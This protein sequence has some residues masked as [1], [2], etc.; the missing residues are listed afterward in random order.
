MVITTQWYIP[1][2]GKY[3]PIIGNGTY[4]PIQLAIVF[5]IDG[6][7]HS[8]LCFSRKHEFSFF[9]TANSFHHE[10]MFWLEGAEVKCSYFKQNNYHPSSPWCCLID[11]VNSMYVKLHTVLHHNWKMSCRC[12]LYFAVYCISC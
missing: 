8:I 6:I 2:N 7:Y 4:H 3:H 12:S 1:P 9:C 11:S 5:T 10:I